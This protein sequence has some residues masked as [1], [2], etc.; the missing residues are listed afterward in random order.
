MTYAPIET[1]AGPTLSTLGRAFAAL[2]GLA[3]CHGDLF[4]PKSV[5]FV[6]FSVPPKAVFVPKR[7]LFGLSAI[8][9]T[10]EYTTLPV[11]SPA[12]PRGKAPCNSSR[13]NPFIPPKKD[14]DGEGE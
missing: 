11:Y 9:P 2:F 4:V 5:P 10:E 12:P 6:P 8:K 7:S 14:G 3:G 13:L 1:Q